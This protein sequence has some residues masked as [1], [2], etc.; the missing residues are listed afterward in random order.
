MKSNLVVKIVI[1]AAFIIM[2]SVIGWLLVDRFRM[3]EENGELVENAEQMNTEIE[4]LEQDLTEMQAELDRKDLAVE[5]KDKLIADKTKELSKKQR[6]IDQLL[7]QGK[8]NAAQADEY[9]G[10]I[11]GME[12]TIKRYEEEITQLKS[13]LASVTS[14]KDA[15]SKEKEAVDAENE[16]L[17]MQKDILQGKVNVAAIL[18]AANFRYT[19]VKNS[20]KESDA[21]EEFKAGRLDNLKV[22]FSILENAVASEGSKNLFI[23][24]LK[25]DGTIARDSKAGTGTFTFEEREL[26]YT[27]SQQINYDRTAQKV[28]VV[29][30][31]DSKKFEKGNLKIKIYCEGFLIGES[32]LNIK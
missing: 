13:Q 15:I 22:Q 18:K 21:E 4:S 10:K 27:F 17:S 29:Y 6:Q 9:R 12:K 3:Q 14:E 28:T 24:I 23:Q 26:P 30:H 16:H 20:G 31:P 11:A 7:K 1:V 8:I 19:N 2:L 32:A 25:P 5:E